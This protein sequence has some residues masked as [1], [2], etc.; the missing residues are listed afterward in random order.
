MM[1]RL[2][3]V[4]CFLAVANASAARAE[5][6]VEAIA[7]HLAEQGYQDMEIGRTFLGRVWIEA[8]KNGL[9]REIIVN[10]R[11]GEILR[12]YWEDEGEHGVLGHSGSKEI[13]SS[14]VKPSEGE[15][16]PDV[17]DEIPNEERSDD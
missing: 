12:D 13:G 3:F 16:G 17:A 2:I 10:P 9:E 7:R 5:T 11:T 1:S 8:E 6:R 15:G 14:S 4:G